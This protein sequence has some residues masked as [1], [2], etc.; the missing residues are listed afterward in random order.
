MATDYFRLLRI[1]HWIKN[2]FVFVPILFSK[3]LFEWIYFSEVLLAFITFS[4]TA[5]M[6]YVFNDLM[7]IEF[8]RQHPVKKYRPIANGSIKPLQAKVILVILYVIIISFLTQLNW[9]FTYALAG[10]I[11]INFLYTVKLKDI[12]IVDLF[13]IASGFMLRVLAGAFVVDIYVSN[14]LILTTIFLALFLAVMKRRSELV[15]YDGN[16]STR[17]VLKDY[18]EKFIDQI[19]AIAAGGLIICYALYSVSER[20]AEQFG[21]DFFVFTT[22]FVVFGIFRYMFLVIKKS[23]G[24]NPTEIMLTDF[25]MIINTALY[26]FVIISI[27]Y[28]F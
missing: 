21:T 28:F 18:S 10:Y 9:E 17:I 15:A 13:C 24:E 12:I 8:D 23:K 6:V 1:S 16:N 22:L 27:I 2:L 4:L 3:H 19:S 5:S 11:L 25:P 26:I 14:W 7:D 20:T